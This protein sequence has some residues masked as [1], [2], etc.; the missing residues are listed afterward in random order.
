MR[1]TRWIM[2]Y[3]EGSRDRKGGPTGGKGM[4]NSVRTQT[5]ARLGE[6]RCWKGSGP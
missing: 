4:G 3:K 2:E 6:G 5:D 1:L